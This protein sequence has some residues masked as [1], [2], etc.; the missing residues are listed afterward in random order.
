MNPRLAPPLC[1]GLML[2]LH[3]AVVLAEPCVEVVADREVRCPYHAIPLGHDAVFLDLSSGAILSADLDDLGASPSLVLDPFQELGWSPGVTFFSPDREH[4][5][6]ARG[7]NGCTELQC[8]FGRPTPWLA[9][10]DADEWVHINLAHL[11]LGANSEIHGWSTWVHGGLA[12]F[13]GLVRAD[14]AGWVG[15]QEENTTQIYAASFVPGQEGSVAVEAFAPD[16]AWRD[17]C[18]TGRLS[19]QPGFADGCFDG[20]RMTVVRRCYDEPDTDATWSW[21]N[22]RNADGSGGTCISA[23]SMRVPVLRTHAVE[24]DASCTPKLPFESWAVV[25]EPDDGPFSRMMGVTPEWGEML[26]SISSDGSSVVVGRNTAD[27]NGDPTDHCG[28]FALNLTDTSDPL[29]GNANRN[30]HVC[31]LGPDLR[32][33]REPIRVATE[34][35]PPENIVLGEFT[36]VGGE[37]WLLFTIEHGALGQPR[38]NRIGA[39]DLGVGVGTEARVTLPF[40][41][42][43]QAFTAL[44]SFREDTSDG[45]GSGSADSGGSDSSD[46][47]AATSTGAADGTGSGGSGGTDAAREAASSGC[48][49]HV[50]SASRGGGDRLSV[51]F[52]LATAAGWRR[53]SARRTALTRRVSQALR[54]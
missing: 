5:I 51:A 52:V 41:D 22:T 33:I 35:L 26:S 7:R 19:A 47:G 1:A 32:C 17:S 28:G 48:S 44:R 2:L 18:L 53:R 43:G 29:S 42:P 45:S 50:E 12:L 15:S 10:R 39:I 38:I 16:A 20:Q 21:W 54:P 46:T 14:D 3:P 23:P 6:V 9:Y 25:H 31:E 27:W 4:A 8:S 13:N 34:L 40:G 36:E 49:C 37:P 30:A 24:L 11:G